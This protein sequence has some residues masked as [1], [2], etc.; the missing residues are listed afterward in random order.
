MLEIMQKSAVRSCQWFYVWLQFYQCIFI[1]AHQGKYSGF[2]GESPPPPC[3]VDVS[4][5]HVCG[6]PLSAE[7]NMLCLRSSL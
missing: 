2:I 3:P 4:T 1:L 5:V 7:F 6:W